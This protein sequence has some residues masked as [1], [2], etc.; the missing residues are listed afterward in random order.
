MIGTGTRF[1]RAALMSWAAFAVSFS[2]PVAFTQADDTRTSSNHDGQSSAIHSHLLNSPFQADDTTV[3]VL[4]PDQLD[5]SR[6]YRVLYVLP[7]VAGAERRFGD[8]L[9]QIRNHGLHNEHGLICV[10]PEF[11]AA[12]WFADHDSDPKKRDESHLLKT[13]VPF[14]KQN[15][16]ALPKA[17]GRL[18]IGFSKSGWGAISLLLRN[19]DT[20]HRAAAWDTGIRIDMGPITDQERSA[21]IARDFGSRRN[22]EQYRLSAL[23]RR[24]G[25]LL[26]EQPRLFY[27]NTEGKRAEGGAALHRLMIKLNVPHRYVLEPKRRHRW[28][29][30][31]IPEAV[32][33]LVTDQ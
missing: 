12:P 8:G 17:E 14:V 29:S 19:P 1:L 3:R 6:Q 9:Q 32:Q 25:Q 11:T 16:P 15:Y 28:D 24:R 30:G 7:V 13:V 4:V 23:L 10:A 26:G 21:R 31:W 22:F 5:R 27:Y 20:F 33:F 18:L 2:L